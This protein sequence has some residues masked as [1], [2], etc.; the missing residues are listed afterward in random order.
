MPEY[1]YQKNLKL[2]RLGSFGFKTPD[3]ISYYYLKDHI[4][5][6]RVTVNEQGDIVTK[7]DYYPFG[8]R[9]PGLSYNNGNRNARLKFQSK[10]LQDY[11]FWKTY[12]F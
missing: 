1:N 10:R 8:L 6:I 9:M 3:K 12:Y 2:W 4:G 11:G 5:N 7:D